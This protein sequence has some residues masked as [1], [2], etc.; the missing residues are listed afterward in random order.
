MIYFS[1]KSDLLFLRQFKERVEGL[2]ELEARVRQSLKPSVFLCG[3]EYHEAVLAR[4]T[5]TERGRALREELAKDISRAS[6]IAHK[7]GATIDVQSIPAPG[8]GGVIIPVNLFY[9]ILKDTSHGGVDQDWIRDTIN[10]TIGRTQ[11]RLR[12]ER[13]NMFNPLYWL[14]QVLVFL[15]RIPF[16]IV[17]VSGFDVSKVEDHFLGK[18]FKLV[19]IGVVIYVLIRLGLD[20]TDIAK[21]IMDLVRGIPGT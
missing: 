5:S 1:T 10:E 9:A 12:L 4:A 17:S 21:Y 15:V 11:Q 20:K 6:D 8:V 13:V 16:H 19:E 18:V 7:N 14:Y 2:W 3:S